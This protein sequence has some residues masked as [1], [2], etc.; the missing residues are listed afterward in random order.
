MQPE[1]M[2]VSSNKYGN[3]IRELESYNWKT[4]QV[5]KYNIPGVSAM[6]AN[7]DGSYWLAIWE[8]GLKNWN[9]AT[10]ELTSHF[11]DSTKNINLHNASIFNLTRDSKG[12]IWI[13]T[14][15]GL[16]RMNSDENEIKLMIP[17]YAI[18][19]IYFDE[20]ILWIGAYGFGLLKYNLRTQ[21]IEEFRSKK[22]SNSLS[23]N[24]VWDI[25]RD[26]EGFLWLATADGLNRFDLRSNEFKVYTESDG[27]GSNYI[28]GLLPGENGSI[29]MSTGS[30]ISNMH[31][32]SKTGLAFR[33]ITPWME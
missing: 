10:Q 22:S 7:N 19:T 6:V 12:N 14:L 16:Y 20:D 9:P 32:D 4:G 30:G 1:L 11:R 17:E 15:N 27:L 24:V 33:I 3:S 23:N 18:S 25:Y 26:K 28:A 8:F 2:F 13:G 29:W 21:D 31:K 5:K